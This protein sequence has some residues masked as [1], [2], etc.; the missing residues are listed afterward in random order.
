MK[1]LRSVALITLA[2]AVAIPNL[3]ANG[4]SEA[5]DEG[6]RTLEVFVFAGPIKEAFWQEVI[7]EFNTKYPEVEVELTAIPK[8]NDQVRP[9]IAASDPPDVYFVA[10][11]NNIPVDQLVAEDLIVSLQPL[12]DAEVWEGGSNFADSLAPGNVK[13]FDGTPY[14][15]VL[16]K[17]IVGFWY[18]EPTFQ[19]KGWDVPKNFADFQALCPEIEAAG[20]APMVTTGIYP[21]YF[22]DFVLKSSVASAAGR[23]ALLDWK[24]LKP[25]F[26]TSEAFRSVL[27]RYQWVIENDYLLKGSEGMNHVA[28]QSEWVHG[29]AAFVPTGTWLEA[30]MKNDFPEGFAEGIRFTPSFFI[31][32][33]DPQ[34][35]HPLGAASM[36]V[37]DTPEQDLSL[38]FLRTLY[39][40]DVI[41]KMTEITNILS[42]VPA[43]NS[44]SQKSA[45][46]SSAVDFYDSLEVVTWPVGGYGSQDVDRELAAKLQGLMTGQI[47]A[48]E[49][50]E[51]LEAK[52][53]EVRND[54]DA[55]FFEAY[56]PE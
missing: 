32:E 3:W 15:I 11:A 34:V 38:E 51:A 22:K 6:P 17:H 56:F 42:I 1:K 23:Q 35:V 47:T 30:E 39:S 10:G 19:A 37:F 26:F 33:N 43:A 18:H 41:K 50:C 25:G 28:S 8:I 49:I 40:K 31:G 5:Q 54:P 52:A 46:V 16:P 12:L 20:M 44:V 21:Y 27:E 29:K 45:A 53:A 14:S 4:E 24:N 2:L 7:A 36:T 55:I 48:E 13:Y 9:R